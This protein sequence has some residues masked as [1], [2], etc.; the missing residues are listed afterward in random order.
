MSYRTQNILS[1][2]AIVVIFMLA[3]LPARSDVTLAAQAATA[4]AP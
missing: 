1:I 2:L 3:A 4:G